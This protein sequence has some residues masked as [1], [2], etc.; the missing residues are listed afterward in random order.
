MRRR[1]AWREGRT[2]SKAYRLFRSTRGVL[3]ELLWQLAKLSKGGM[4]IIVFTL[5]GISILVTETL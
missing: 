4:I 2:R 3:G 1:S 5:D